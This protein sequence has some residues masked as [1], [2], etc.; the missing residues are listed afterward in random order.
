M[1]NYNSNGKLKG[2]IS[3]PLKAPSKPSLSPTVTSRPSPTTS[4]KPIPQEVVQEEV[5][6]DQVIQRQEIKIQKTPLPPGEVDDGTFLF[7]VLVGLFAIG[8]L[9]G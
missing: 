2:G 6:Q 1:I 7:W 4:I 9:R 3:N 8:M 5:V